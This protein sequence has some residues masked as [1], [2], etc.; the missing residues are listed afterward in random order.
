ML[1][2]Q[3]MDQRGNQKPMLKHIKINFSKFMKCSIS[4]S[5][6]TVYSYIGLP[7]KTRNILNI[8]SNSTPKETRKRRTNQSK[9]N[10][11]NKIVKS[12]WK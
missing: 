8:Q 2:R 11:K 9:V 12:D 6:R 7:Q 4:S 3:P 10:R 1:L 5:M